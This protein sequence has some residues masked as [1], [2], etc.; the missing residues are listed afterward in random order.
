MNRLE[1]QKGVVFASHGRGRQGLPVPALLQL[2][3]FL[4]AT[5]ECYREGQADGAVDAI[6]V[7]LLQVSPSVHARHIRSLCHLQE[8]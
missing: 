3:S 1:G 8:C 6:C 7:R 4:H 2:A 5:T